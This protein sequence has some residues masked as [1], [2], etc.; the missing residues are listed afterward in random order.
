VGVPFNLTYQIG[1]SFPN[2]SNVT[3]SLNRFNSLGNF[4]ELDPLSV[5]LT[6][7][8]TA[9]VNNLYSFP[10]GSDCHFTIPEYCTLSLDLWAGPNH[11]LTCADLMIFDH[12]NDRMI[13]LTIQVNQTDNPISPDNFAARLY[14]SYGINGAA[15]PIGFDPAN[16]VIPNKT[17][18]QVNGGIYTISFTVS[19]YLYVQNN[20]F[21]ALYN[22]NM[23]ATNLS[24]QWVMGGG[25]LNALVQ[26]A[27]IK[28]TVSLAG[29]PP[30]PPNTAGIV[31][32]A[33][34]LLI[35]S[36][37]LFLGVVFIKKFR[38]SIYDSFTKSC[39]PKS[40]S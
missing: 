39:E 24:S 17:L 31:A 28:V 32:L 12:A 40:A 10:K 22:A 4:T 33:V 5:N 30:S 23:M 37:A 14:N 35:I 2:N 29:P 19:D 16:T 20:Q 15:I 9:L 18:Y 34:I 13:T 21:V 1:G 26:G 38:P 11:Y 3:F 8:K 7:P 27:V 6:Q 25:S 36:A